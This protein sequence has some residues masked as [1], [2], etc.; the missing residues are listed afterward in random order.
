M[1]ERIKFLENKID[2]LEWKIEILQEHVEFRGVFDIL[3]KLNITENQFSQIKDVIRKYS[4]GYKEIW[5]ENKR[6][7][8]EGEFAKIND[9]FKTNTQAVGE[10]LK[11]IAEEVNCPNYKLLFVRL[12]GHM[13]K[14]EDVFSEIR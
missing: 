10:I 5:D 11:E 3:I 12:Y 8:F 1:E 4:R 6:Y 14:Y 2:L 9:V 13:S 7:S